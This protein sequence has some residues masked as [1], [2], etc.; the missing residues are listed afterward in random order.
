M[1]TVTGSLVLS[2]EET[3]CS[4]PTADGVEYQVSGYLIVDVWDHDSMNPD[5][6]LGMVMIPLRD[7]PTV[8]PQEEWYPLT[9]RNAKEK[10]YGSILLELLLKVDKNKVQ[11]R[12]I[13]VCVLW[14]VAELKG[15]I[16]ELKICIDG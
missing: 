4:I 5:D 11:G 9:R 13:V 2:I 3:F 16:A 7:V 15:P 14:L 10:V 6:F 12:A 1:S 8:S